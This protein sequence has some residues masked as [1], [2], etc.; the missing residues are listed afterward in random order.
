M[1]GEIEKIERGIKTQSEPYRYKKRER[2]SVRET[3][4]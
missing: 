4:R 2:Q 3:E 1:K